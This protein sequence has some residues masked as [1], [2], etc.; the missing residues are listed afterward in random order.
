MEGSDCNN[1]KLTV[2][3]F[4]RL[5]Q[6]A[7]VVLVDENCTLDTFK[8]QL[9]LANCGYDRS[10]EL[11]YRHH[12]SSNC[13]YP[14]KTDEQFQA[15]KRVLSVME[16]SFWGTFATTCTLLPYYEILKQKVEDMQFRHKAFAVFMMTFIIPIRFIWPFVLLCYLVRTFRPK[17]A[18]PA[19][20]VAAAASAAP[21][22]EPTRSVYRY[23][24]QLKKLYD[25]GFTTHV[26]NIPLLEK[27]NGDINA[28]V[29]ELV[30]IPA[31]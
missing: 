17:E 9:V 15:I 25:L 7:G 10:R 13:E 20:T 24:D 1:N 11:C 23:T 31:K 2:L 26:T 16:V 21:P 14:L 4:D 30:Q 22:V 3:V 19:A 8:D 29:T 18:T 27:H 5:W 12:S 6:K 28:V